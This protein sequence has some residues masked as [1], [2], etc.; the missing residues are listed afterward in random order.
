MWFFILAVLKR[1]NAGWP[2]RVIGATPSQRFADAVSERSV[3]CVCLRSL[4]RQFAILPLFAQ[5]LRD[6]GAAMLD[7]SSPTYEAM[8]QLVAEAEALGDEP[9]VPSAVDTTVAQALGQRVQELVRV[10]SDFN[11]MRNP[12]VPREV[13]AKQLAADFEQYFGYSKFYVKLI[14]RLFNAAEALA[15]FEAN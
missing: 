6:R 5:E 10:L 13:Y 2:L 1:R 4:R 11:N 15:F 8:K 12:A 14:M 7:E 3:L 9:E